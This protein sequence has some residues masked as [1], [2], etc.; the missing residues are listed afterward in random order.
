M[1]E[2]NNEKP[3]KL[4]VKDP[5]KQILDENNTENVILF[6]DE[7]KPIE[8]EQI[9]LIPLERTN[10]LYAILIPITPM[11]GV[12]EGEGVLFVIDEENSN[13]EIVRDEK[14]IDEVLEIYQKLIEDDDSNKGNK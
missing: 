11:K 12:N 3:K 10:K 8:F 14:I 7:N 5:I 1:S 4:K 6:D 13:M 2:I 9:A